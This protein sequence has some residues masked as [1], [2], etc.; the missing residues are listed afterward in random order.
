MLKVWGIIKM[1][2]EIFSPIILWISSFCWKKRIHGWRSPC[3]SRRWNSISIFV[4]HFRLQVLVH[5]R[6]R[7]K[8]YLIRCLWWID[9]CSWMAKKVS[10]CP[11]QIPCIRSQTSVELNIYRGLRT[12]ASWLGIHS[13]P[14]NQPTISHPSPIATVQQTS[15]LIFCV[16]LSQQYLSSRINEVFRFDDSMITLHKICQMPM[17]LSVQNDFA[18]FWRLEKLS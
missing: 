13:I 15:H 1:S 11:R 5:G 16:P 4:L 7:L 12:T 2:S 6:T 10:L 17:E 9:H 8:N 3:K 18:L 14:Q